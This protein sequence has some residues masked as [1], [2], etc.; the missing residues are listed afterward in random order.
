MTNPPWLSV[1]NSTELPDDRSAGPDA[2][3]PR[4]FDVYERLG[5][6]DPTGAWDSFCRAHNWAASF[7]GASPADGAGDHVLSI[8]PA[9]GGW[10]LS[11]VW[12]LPPAYRRARWLALRSAP[13]GDGRATEC[14]PL[15]VVGVGALERSG[16]VDDEALLIRLRDLYIPAGLTACAAGRELRAEEA[17]FLWVAVTAMAMG[18]ARHLLETTARLAPEPVPPDSPTAGL[19]AALDRR[20]EAVRRDL[21]LAAASG[22]GARAVTPG[23]VERVEESHHL[24]RDVYAAAYQ[25]ALPRTRSVHPLESIMTGSVP[26]LQHARFMTSLLP[27][28]R[29]T[30]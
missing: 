14:H 10:L 21:T 30:S 17:E 15:Y 18:A 4:V 20:R 2:G 12:R 29:T 6:A 28:A 7:P 11:G 1:P 19:G 5:H 23:I 16:A 24:V 26:V 22:A 3:L 13:S 9:E 25:Y 27:S 8:R